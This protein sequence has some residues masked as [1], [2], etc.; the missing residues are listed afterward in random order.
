M[1][2]GITDRLMINMHGI[3]TT[4]QP[5]NSSY[6]LFNVYVTTKTRLFATAFRSHNV[7]HSI[8]TRSLIAAYFTVNC[9]ISVSITVDNIPSS[10]T[11]LLFLVVAPQWQTTEWRGEGMFRRT[12]RIAVASNIS[13]WAQYTRQD[14]RAHGS[15]F[16]YVHTLGTLFFQ[17]FLY[18]QLCG[19][20]HD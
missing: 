5:D 18:L 14:P 6:L 20:F 1:G 13:C 10:I 16:K 4:H 15:N 17:C 7:I 8:N 11:D 19:K 9:L 3:H 2:H 12:C